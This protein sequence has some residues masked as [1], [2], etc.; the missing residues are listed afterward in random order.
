MSLVLDGEIR[1]AAPC[2]QFIRRWKRLRRTDVETAAALSAVIGFGCIG[3]DL[4]RGE[5]RSQEQPGAEFA[6]NEIGVF[7]LPANAGGLCDGFFHHGGGIHEEFDFGLVAV[8]NVA[9]ETPQLFFDD[10]VVVVALRID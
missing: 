2:I 4:E 5:D 6:A 8:G 9:G 3:F 1:D 7:A 10:I